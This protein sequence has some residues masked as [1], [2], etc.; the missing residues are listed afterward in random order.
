VKLLF[1]YSTNTDVGKTFWN[2][3]FIRTYSKI[4]F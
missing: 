2:L 4:L 3:S 1:R